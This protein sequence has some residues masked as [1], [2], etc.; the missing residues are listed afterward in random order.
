MA[1]MAVATDNKVSIT[2]SI[3]NGLST[4]AAHP[5]TTLGIAFLFGVFPGLLLYFVLPSAWVGSLGGTGLWTG[6]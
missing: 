3:G 1:S 5:L 2:R 4:I 6:G